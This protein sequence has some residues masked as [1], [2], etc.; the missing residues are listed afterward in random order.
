MGEFGRRQL[1]A[2]S[3]VAGLALVLGSRESSA[4][5]GR[6]DQDHADQEEVP[7]ENVAIGTVVE[8]T[9]VAAG[10]VTL[11]VGAETIVAATSSFPVDWT[12]HPGDQVVVSLDRHEACPLVEMTRDGDGLAWNTVNEDQ[13]NERV[14]ARTS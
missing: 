5:P 11:S 8:E 14:I 10:V 2:G 9:A 13:A 1:V 6:A 12:L 3:S 4:A 7:T